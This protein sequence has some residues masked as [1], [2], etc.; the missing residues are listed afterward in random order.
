MD[1]ASKFTA[2]LREGP[3]ACGDQ[4]LVLTHEGIHPPKR[5]RVPARLVEEDA[6]DVYELVDASH[7]PMAATYSYRAT[8]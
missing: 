3:N 4:F 6:V 7:W 5:L 1:S 2:I 8:A